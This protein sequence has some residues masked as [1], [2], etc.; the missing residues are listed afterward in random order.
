LK[1]KHPIRLLVVDDHPAFRTGITALIGN[2]PDME[3]VAEAGDGMDAV[4][5]FRRTSVDITLM[6]LRLPGLSGVEATLAILKEFPAARIIVLTTFDGDED[7]H[8][9]LQ[10]GAKSY[11][12]KDMSRQEITGA[13]RVVHAGQVPLALPAGVAQRLAERE[14]RPALTQRETEVLHFLTK[15]FGNREIATSLHVSEDTVKCHLKSVYCKLGVQ[16]RTAAAVSALRHGI[17]H[18]D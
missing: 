5:L 12:L 8:R 16:D 3:V 10:A 7:I 17:V 18:L 4:E 14:R 11:L 15:G 6:D 9:A 13:I 2:E 1:K